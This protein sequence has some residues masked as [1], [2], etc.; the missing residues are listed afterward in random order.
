MNH[1]VTKAE[2]DDATLTKDYEGIVYNEVNVK[3]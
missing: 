2:E 3:Q 1:K